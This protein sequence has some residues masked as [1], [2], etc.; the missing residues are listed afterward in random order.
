MTCL[1]SRPL[2]TLTREEAFL[3]LSEHLEALTQTRH[4]L[5]YFNRA[6]FLAY[7]NFFFLLNDI[8]GMLTYQQK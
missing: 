8:F 6:R 1:K 4:V 2:N 3:E 7:N 5:K